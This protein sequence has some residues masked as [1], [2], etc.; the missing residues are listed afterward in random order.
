LLFI[1]VGNWQLT[2]LHH[3]LL[4]AAFL[5]L[6][7]TTAQLHHPQKRHQEEIAGKCLR[8]RS[9]RHLYDKQGQR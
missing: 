3:L 9:L 5:S 8:T 6:G 4:A 1:F 7:S 2:T